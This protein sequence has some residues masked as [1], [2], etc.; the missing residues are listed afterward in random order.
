[1]T[2]TI[3]RQAR[4]K[5]IPTVKRILGP[6]LEEDAYLHENLESLIGKLTPDRLHCTV[7]EVDDVICA[8]TLWIVEEPNVVR[9]LAFQEGR[10]NCAEGAG[11][12]LLHEEIIEWAQMGISRV[13]IEVPEALGPRVIGPL[14]KWG[15]LVEGLSRGFGV[16]CKPR[17]R[18]SKHFLYRTIRQKEVINF[19][20]EVLVSLGYEVRRDA[21]GLVYRVRDEFRFPFIFSQWHRI[22]TSGPDIIVHPPAS[23]V[24]YSYSAGKKEVRK[25]LP[26]LFYIN[27]VGAVGTARVESS[28]LED[29]EY[30]ASR[31]EE[32]DFLDTEVG[33][34]E[35]SNKAPK[36]GKVLVVHF[37]WYRPLIRPVTLEEIRGMD[38]K[39]NPQRSRSISCS[40]FESIIAA[41][42]RLE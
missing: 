18:M 21:D 15:F 8:V 5:D 37:Q 14:Q 22:T 6:W 12:R 1:M 10:E 29:P 38:A 31:L 23:N 4:R 17:V 32:M 9:V 16:D 19:I 27:R 13:T 42:D 26:L 20:H 41:G 40:L 7:L 3:L 2:E 35:N 24:A 39:F 30:A 36:I 33:T 25:G 28:H 11:I 34:G